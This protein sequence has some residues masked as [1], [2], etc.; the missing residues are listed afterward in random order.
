[1]SLHA[2]LIT[3][4][5]FPFLH[6]LPQTEL[7]Y[8]PV[9]RYP[10]T[11]YFIPFL[12]DINIKV[13]EIELWPWLCHWCCSTFKDLFSNKAWICLEVQPDDWPCVSGWRNVVRNRGVYITNAQALAKV[14]FIVV[15]DNNRVGFAPFSVSLCVAP[16]RQVVTA[17]C[18]HLCFYRAFYHRA[19]KALYTLTPWFSVVTGGEFKL[20]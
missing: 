15:L 7:K 10:R 3:F 20:K 19:P 9:M 12:E 8:E 16:T 1:M 4:H 13:I 11:S 6:V 17:I 5:S 18:L 14:T 2:L